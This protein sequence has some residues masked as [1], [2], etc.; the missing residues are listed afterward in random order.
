MREG[1]ASLCCFNSGADFSGDSRVTSQV[2]GLAES[3]C[4]PGKEGSC[5]AGTG[6]SEKKSRLGSGLVKFIVDPE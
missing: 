5:R 2:P 1:G 3:P 4:C 6:V